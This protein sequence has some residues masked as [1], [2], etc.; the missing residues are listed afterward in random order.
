[1]AWVTY[2]HADLGSVRAPRPLGTCDRCGFTYNRDRLRWQYDWAGT[3]QMNLGIL[4]C[5][6]CFDDSQAQLKSIKIPIDPV[7]I[8]NPRPGEF[9]G[10]AITAN[11]DIFDTVVPSQ[12]VVETGIEG[13]FT[14][15]GITQIGDRQPIVTESASQ[16]FLNEV[17][18]TPVPYDE[19]FTLFSTSVAP[20]SI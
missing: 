12:I 4:V 15:I 20:S 3:K 1:M 11:P 9:N 8:L 5:H 10:M 18:V 13:D 14:N 17:T 2:K 6:S 19:G 16:P 7:S